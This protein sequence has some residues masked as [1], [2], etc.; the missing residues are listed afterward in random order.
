MEEEKDISFAF[1]F[2]DITREENWFE[3][4]RNWRIIDDMNE[5]Y[6]TKLLQSNINILIY[7]FD[8]L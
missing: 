2:T 5:I 3:M 8:K 7:K 6:L 1:F 4:K